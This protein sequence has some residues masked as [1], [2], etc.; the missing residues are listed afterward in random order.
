M[1]NN[2]ILD[3]K[4][5]N[6]AYLKMQELETQIQNPNISSWKRTRLQNQIN[7]IK[8]QL[9]EEDTTKIY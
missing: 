2:G 1:D 9:E 5:I 7:Q 3:V 6:S 8:A 4:E